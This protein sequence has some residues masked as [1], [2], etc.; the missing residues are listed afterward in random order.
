MKSKPV[1]NNKQPGVLVEAGGGRLD[2][3]GV[4]RNWPPKGKGKK[5][6]AGQKRKKKK[7]KVEGWGKKKKRKVGGGGGPFLNKRGL[8]GKTESG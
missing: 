6:V 5:G 1:V 8:V 2:G 7:R 4:E 3:L